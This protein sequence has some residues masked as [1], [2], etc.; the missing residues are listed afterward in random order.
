MQP[1]ER[2]V[3][4]EIGSEAVVE[5]P[6][7]RV[8]RCPELELRVD[9]VGESVG[10]GVA[11]RDSAEAVAADADLEMVVPLTE[12]DVDR[13]ILVLVADGDLVQGIFGEVLD[14]NE[15]VPH[16]DSTLWNG[17]LGARGTK[18]PNTK[19]ALCKAISVMLRVFCA[20]ATVGFDEMVEVILSV[21][22]A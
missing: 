10:S 14:G 8:F 9:P 22:V 7:N 16:R 11:E 20:P 3:A 4:L 13:D 17:L 12:P 6:Q 5:D 18:H 15:K 21:V 19:I 1:N 2:L